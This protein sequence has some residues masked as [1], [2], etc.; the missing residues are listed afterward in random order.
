[1]SG[2][3]PARIREASARNIQLS[4]RLQAVRMLAQEWE[5]DP[6]QDWGGHIAREFGRRLRERL[7]GAS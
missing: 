3:D 2:Q 1:M 6:H 4:R 5:S 7:D